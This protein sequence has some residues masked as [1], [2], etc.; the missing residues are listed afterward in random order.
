M[1]GGRDGN[2]VYGDCWS[3]HVVKE[4]NQVKLTWFLLYDSTNSLYNANESPGTRFGCCLLPLCSGSC[5]HD[6]VIVIG[7][8]T[9]LHGTCKCFCDYFRVDSS[10]I[11]YLF[12]ISKRQWFVLSVSEGFDLLQHLNSIHSTQLGS[13]S[14][15]LFGLHDSTLQL[16]C[17]TLHVHQGVLQIHD[18]GA[19]LVPQQ[20]VPVGYTVETLEDHCFFLGGGCTFFWNRHFNSFLMITLPSSL[21]SSYEHSCSLIESHSVSRKRLCSTYALPPSEQGILT[22]LD[23]TKLKQVK[24]FLET[25]HLY[26]K[27]RKITRIHDQMYAVPVLDC[28]RLQ[29]CLQEMPESLSRAISLEN[30]NPVTIEHTSYSVKANIERQLIG[31]CQSCHFFLFISFIVDLSPF[32]LH[33]IE[34]LGDIII[35]NQGSFKGESWESFWS[36]FASS[37]SVISHSSTLSERETSFLRILCECYG[38]KRVGIHEEIDCGWNK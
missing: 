34:V 5:Q 14:F 26:D 29:Q 28:T 12:K 15:L 4:E 1:Y 17:L 24:I 11:P 38:C 36:V 27:S 30:T 8:M 23:T 18:M 2:R 22:V 32:Q 37:P 3:V 13:N 21:H 31:W 16:M 6:E 10:S 7:G 9:D 20:I 35:L 25:A 33:R 19:T